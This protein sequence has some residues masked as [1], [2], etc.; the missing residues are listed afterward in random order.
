MARSAD[1]ARP[2][3]PSVLDCGLVLLGV[4]AA[5]RWLGFGR[6]LTLIRRLTAGAPAAPDDEPLVPRATAHAVATAGAFFPGRALCLEQSLALYYCLRRRGIAARL[7]L[8][9]QSHPFA[10]HA[11]VEWRDEPLNDTRERLKRFLPL[12]DVAP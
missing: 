5:L 9:V 2:A 10:A 7:R 11:W 3:V 12:P 8:G 4:K 6:T 1:A